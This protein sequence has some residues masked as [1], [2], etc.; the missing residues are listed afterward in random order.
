[1]LSDACVF[2][3]LWA[4]VLFS[5]GIWIVNIF[6]FMC[7]EY[8]K[9]VFHVVYSELP[10]QETG[11]IFTLPCCTTDGSA[12]LLSCSWSAIAGYHSAGHPLWSPETSPPLCPC[13]FY[14]EASWTSIQKENP[15][16]F[17]NTWL[18]GHIPK[19]VDGKIMPKLHHCLL[20]PSS[21]NMADC[22]GSSA[23]ATPLLGSW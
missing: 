2:V 13:S 17:I 4:C 3:V 11:D 19:K 20:T 1:M 12:S 6:F 22:P 7:H 15:R 21:S 14:L 8:W 9:H 16:E 18:K 5:A 10:E 23:S